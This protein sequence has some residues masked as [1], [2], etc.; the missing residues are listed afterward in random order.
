MALKIAAFVLPLGFDTFAVAV[1]LGLRG[2]QPLRPALLFALFETAMPLLGIVAGDYAG[3]RF[4]ALAVYAGGVILI[5]IGVH[6]LRE[7]LE[8]DKGRSPASLDSLRGMILAGFGISTDELAVGFPL[9]ALRLPPAP[10]VCAIGV[11]AFAITAAGIWIGRLIGAEA[12][13]RAA[14]TAGIAAGAAFM[15]LGCYTIAERIL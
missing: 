6:V 10:V 12:G 4:D 11:Q 8:P 13:R 15:M 7:T 3:R 1:A 2:I 9:G 14:R 5:G